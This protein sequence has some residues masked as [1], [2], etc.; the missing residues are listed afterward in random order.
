M[1]VQDTG[2]S[3]HLPTGEGIVGFRT[4]DE[5]VDGARSIADNYP[6]HC[7]AARRIAEQNFDSGKVLGRMMEETGVSP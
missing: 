6:S 5:A 7:R 1:L 2:F 3:D 4:L